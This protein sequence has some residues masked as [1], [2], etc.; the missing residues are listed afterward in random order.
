MVDFD[1]WVPAEWSA[2]PELIQEWLLR[3]FGGL[4]RCNMSLLKSL[5]LR[6]SYLDYILRWFIFLLSTLLVDIRSIWF[7]SDVSPA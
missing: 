1:G 7:Q 4:E 3:E 5:N 6:S 2:K